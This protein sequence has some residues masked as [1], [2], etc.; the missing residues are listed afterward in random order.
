MDVL[1]ST[2]SH[3][4][5]S[6]QASK[7]AF[8]SLLKRKRKQNYSPYLHKKVCVFAYPCVV[9]NVIEN[10]NEQCTVWNRVGMLIMTPKQEMIFI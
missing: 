8:L 4:Q 10:K 1:H 9:I 2:S 7:L 6:S 5:V 3:W